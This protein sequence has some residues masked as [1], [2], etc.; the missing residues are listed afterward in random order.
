MFWQFMEWNGTLADSCYVSTN[1]RTNLLLL[2]ETQNRVFQ[3]VH[4]PV[5]AGPDS[6]RRLLQL[7]LRNA[8]FD[9]TPVSS[10]DGAGNVGDDVLGET[11]HQNRQRPVRG[12][13]RLPSER[14]L[15]IDRFGQILVEIDGNGWRLKMTVSTGGALILRCTKERKKI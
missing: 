1:D 5:D 2:N 14:N 8:N 4:F 3:I 9:E 7:V 10:V 12:K 15:G 11:L 13:E 6:G